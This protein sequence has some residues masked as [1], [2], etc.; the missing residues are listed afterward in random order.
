MDDALPRVAAVYV[1][2][3]AYHDITVLSAASLIRATD[4]A[5]DIFIFQHG[6][7]RPV[8]ESL[9]QYAAAR[10]HRVEVTGID[11]HTAP[12]A[13][14]RRRP[15]RA[16]VSDTAYLKPRAVEA[17][18]DRYDAILYADGDVLFFDGFDLDAVT[19]IPEL[20]SACVDF[21][22]VNG[23]DYEALSARCAETGY[24]PT[25]INTGV[26]IL[27]APRWRATDAFERFC[28]NA[29]RHSEDCPYLGDGCRLRD[30]CPLNMTFA[31]DL[32]VL[33]A[34]YNVQRW[35]LYTDQWASAKV[36][37]YTGHQ[38]F[39]RAPVYWVDRKERRLLRDLRGILGS[40][41]LPWRFHDG[42][43]SYALNRM[44]RRHDVRQREAQLARR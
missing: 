18:A 39:E 24:D 6:Y 13:D 34:T 7:T 36:R 44:R 23:T 32:R 38:N 10:G 28:E 14:G 4:R 27:N 19:S 5:V 11:G 33:P 43:V 1:T 21:P 40:G 8:P 31:G 15:A 41:A 37:H 3:A 2:D 25:Y 42:G 30:Q 22:L 16:Y 12:S 26:M 35:A 17:L 9:V 20:C 29:A